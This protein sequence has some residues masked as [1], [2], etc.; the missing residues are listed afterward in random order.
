M[1]GTSSVPRPTFGPRGFIAH[2]EPEILEGVKAD[3][4]AAYGGR[5]NFETTDGSAVNATPQSQQASSLTAIIGDS[6]DVFLLLCNGVDPA[7]ADGR[8]QDG[9]ARIYFI[10]RLPAQPTVVTAT[11]TGLVN[12][13]IPVGAQAIATDGTIFNCT[14]GGTIPIGGTIDL[15][16]TAT[17][18][19]PIACPAT[20]LNRIYRLVPGWDTI[21][22]AADGVLGRLSETRAAFEARRGLSVAANSVGML[23]SI[24][25]SVLAVEDV[26]DAYATENPTGSPVT[27]G[28]VSIAAH[29][30]Y[31]A[32][33]GGTNQAVAEAIWRKKAPGCGYV[34]N[35]TVT[36]EDSQS[37]YA[38]PYPSYDVTFERPAATTV[39]FVVRIA[40]STTVP[41]T[42]LSQIQAA[43]IAAFA[44]SDGGQRARIGGDIY[45]SR[46]YGPVAALGSWAQIVSLHVASGSAAAVTASIATT[47]MT[48][49]AVAS[50]T[51][52]VG[53]LVT[54]VG[55]TP[56]T[57]ITALGS[58]SG[59]NG[60]YT[61][62]ISQTK[63]SAAVVTYTL[64]NLVSMDIDQAPVTS[65]ADITLILV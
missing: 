5:L 62:S 54:G 56:G 22:N 52:A 12:T 47:V 3:I 1:S 20:T 55:V 46:F 60:T 13:P 38:I 19:G 28:G 40:D 31:V 21:T 4:N 11:C 2:T 61:V 50:G 48:V 26:L 7:F 16:F 15:Q 24:L 51:L 65:A 39:L 29:S 25:G 18:D 32:V 64:A 59:G 14:D 53:Q 58:G 35:T 17:V 33:S 42:A 63:S 43:I 34:G 6:N 8:M 36:V 27:I 23:S 45:A 37:G 57:T 44:G 41:S 49:T 9:I 30:L 10:T